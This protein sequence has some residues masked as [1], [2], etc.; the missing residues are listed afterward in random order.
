[1]HAPELGLGIM[2]FQDEKGEIDYARV[3]DTIQ[4]YMNGEYCIFDLHPG[5]VM[6]KAQTILREYVVKKYPRDRFQVANKM[7]YYGI[8]SFSD[9]EKIFVEELES[10]GLEFF[11]NYMLHALTKDVYE[12]HETLGGFDFL[13]VL[14]LK[15][16]AE[17]IGFSFHD[18]PELLEHI[19][20][21]HP[22]IDFVQLQ[23][24]IFDWSNPVIASKACYEIARKYNKSIYVMEPLKGGGLINASRYD[25]KL[26]ESEVAKLCLEFVA[27]LDGIKVILSG[28]TTPE[29]VKENRTTL[30]NARC[31]MIENSA[32]ADINK[33][34]NKSNS[35]QCTKCGYCKRECPKNIAIPE[36]IGLINSCNNSGVND[37]TALGRHKI[38]YRG[39]I[40]SKHNAGECVQCGK[41]EI[42]CPQKL[43][44]RKYMKQAKSMFEDGYNVGTRYT[45]ERNAQILIYLL[46]QHNIK[47]VVASPGTTNVCLVSSIQTDSFFN[48]YSAPDERSAAYIACGIAQESGEPVVLSCTGATSSRNYYSGLTEAYYSKLPI[49]AVT[50]SRRS[51]RIGHNF[52]QVTDR[53]CPPRD[54]V[55]LSVNAPYI[56]DKEDEWACEIAINKALLEVK[57]YGGIPVHINLETMYSPNMSATVLPKARVINRLFINDIMPE[58][59]ADRVAIVV[60]EHTRWTA[61][62]TKKV[63]LFCEK[64]NAAVF[65]DHTSNYHGAFRVFANI[66]AV[67]KNRT[68]EFEKADLIISIGN[69]SSSEYGI[70]AYESWRINPDGEIR[71]TFWSLTNVFEMEEIEF[72]EKY[73]C[74]ERPIKNSEYYQACLNEEQGL[75]QNMPELPFSNPYLASVTISRL[76]R[77]SV[78]HLAIRNSL[79][80]WNYFRA[81]ESI[82]IHANTGGFGIDGSIST[83]LGNSLTS[84]KICY[85]V[86]GDL[87]FFYDMNALGNRH[88]NENIR[89][90]LVNNGTGMEMQFTGFLADKVR[91][92]KDSYI[93]ASGHYGNKSVSVVKDFAKNLGFIYLS[94]QNKEEYVE[95][96]KT[97]CSGERL[98]KPV[99]LEAFINKDDE[100]TA[101]TL[102][103]EMN[104]TKRCLE[105]VSKRTIKPP[106]RLAKLDKSELVI[107]GTGACFRNNID[108]ILQEKKVRY[109]CDN[110]PDKWG[111]D[112]APGIKCISPEQLSKLANPFILIALFGAEDSMQVTNQLMDLGINQFDHI[113]NWLRYEDRK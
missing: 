83:I 103:S 92:D 50:S 71:D 36:I 93:A 113:S 65:C 80:S 85:C 18:K 59:N 17:N 4:E 43:E 3:L 104:G 84:D 69:I 24:N 21:K 105:S 54:V 46:K 100:D 32:I 25:S 74:D 23:I 28:M 1:M 67:Q 108:A 30:A 112:I 68:F 20:S 111:K 70:K 35:V 39:Y 90:L 6:S 95:G 55:K 33:A 97:F 10:C 110:N 22:E 8:Y 9:Y 2:R 42:H 86:L 61:D 29:Q 89:I 57:R 48:I 16:L 79:R 91:A 98:S 40:N 13:K 53:T 37:T 45:D 77:E 96:L 106:T 107:F 75:M 5:Y 31:K 87:A 15:G 76:P 63:D 81:D 41:C 44:I 38:F 94:A 14:K 88:I 19:L 11:D 66:M 64:Y 7:P 82:I 62:L 49:I 60:G 109:A 56:R 99:I 51:D 34:Y 52:D 101:Y 26:T 12:M 78:L 47:Q 72:F 27:K 58:I 73:V 102:I